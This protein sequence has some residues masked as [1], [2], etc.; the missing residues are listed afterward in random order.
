MSTFTQEFFWTPNE[1]VGW[2][3]RLSRESDLWLVAWRFGHNAVTVHAKD[4]L[5]SWFEG[6]DESVQLFI[7]FPALCSEPIW[8]VAGGLRELDFP[9]SYAVQLVP[10]IITSDDRSL[11]QGRL[12]IMRKTDYDDKSRYAELSKRYRF[13]RA[14]LKRNSDAKHVIVQAL[15][16][17]RRKRWLD[18][19]VSTAVVDSKPIL[20]QFSKGEVEFEIDLA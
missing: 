16:S 17:G 20:R 1:L 4:I 19:L 2:V 3:D 8:R 7:G 13:L 12:A 9:R 11:L 5:P 18:M 14:D 15:S 6:A 10:S